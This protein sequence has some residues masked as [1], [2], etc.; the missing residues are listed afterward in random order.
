[1][2]D[3]HIQPETYEHCDGNGWHGDYY[4]SATSQVTIR[5]VKKQKL[6]SQ[7]PSSHSRKLPLSC[8]N[9]FIVASY[10]LLWTMASGK[11]D[12]SPQRRQ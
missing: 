9:R 12:L 3:R 11:I 1:M 4:L 5:D 2:N 10:R 7:R 8:T 6:H